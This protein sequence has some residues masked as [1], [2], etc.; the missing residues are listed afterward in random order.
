MT[1]KKIHLPE[2]LKTTL[3][4]IL[5]G[6][7]FVGYFVFYK[8]GGQAVL[9]ASMS[10]TSTPDAPSV[11]AVSLP[12]YTHALTIGGTHIK[13]A[14]ALTGSQQEQG[15]SYTPALA[16]NNGMLF[17]FPS[18]SVV[19]FWM[20]DMNYSLDIIWIGSDKTVKD[21]TPDLALSTYPNSFS[22]KVPVRYALEVP[23]GFAAQ[24]GITVGSIVSF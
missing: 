19:P 20:K 22:P 6:L 4:F 17:V 15:L 10:A 24:N 14:F 2:W 13:V 8:P 9:P 12:S 18:D 23:A 7:L 5:L 16:P 1:V 21:I 3:S 11:P